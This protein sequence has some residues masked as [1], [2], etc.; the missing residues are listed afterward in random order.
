MR[1]HWISLLDTTK[2]AEVSANCPHLPEVL[3]VLAENYYGD[4]LYVVTAS[5]IYLLDF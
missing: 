2:Y 5:K 1:S 3:G 4:A